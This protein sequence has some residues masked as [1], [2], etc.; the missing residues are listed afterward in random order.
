MRHL[1][2]SLGLTLWASAGTAFDVEDQAV[3]GDPEASSTLRIL[4]TADISFFTPMILSYL[5]ANPNVAVDY[6]VASST[7][8]ISWLRVLR[9]TTSH[10]RSPCS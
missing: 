1:I 7:D 3:F 10:E 4:S 6:T 9:V 2:L 8:V 5:E